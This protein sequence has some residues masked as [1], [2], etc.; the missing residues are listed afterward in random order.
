VE[1]ALDDE[2]ADTQPEPQQ[3]AKLDLSKYRTGA[4]VEH[5][6]ELISIPGSLILIILTTFLLMIAVVITVMIMF[7]NARL[8]GMM[9]IVTCGY[10]LLCA[11]VLGPLLG[12]L[13]LTYRGLGNTE[14][15]LKI[16]L[17]IAQQA[18]ID[19]ENLQSGT[20]RM[21]SGPELVGQVYDGVVLPAL[22]Q[23]VGGAFSIFGTPILW[24]Y[25]RTIGSAV[26]YLL[27]K[28]E[29]PQ[30]TAEQE[31]Q[32]QN[33][34]EQG[35]ATAAN[36]SGRIQ[37]YTSRATAVVSSIGGGLRIY[38]M[39]PLFLLFG[40]LLLVAALPIILYRIW[41]GTAVEQEQ[42]LN[43]LNQSLSWHATLIDTFVG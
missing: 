18:A 4:L 26:R 42:L 39:R 5:L 17:G 14:E 15:I 12:I 20:A 16:I 6:I 1:I 38:I 29:P 3:V 13:R 9:W 43:D 31:T 36:Y 24:M 22:G 41:V 19:N 23:A 10:S 30:L 35:I 28:V 7:Y 37:K 8:S 2:S 34:L 21:P 11:A 25:R 32:I 33:G 40:G 27:R